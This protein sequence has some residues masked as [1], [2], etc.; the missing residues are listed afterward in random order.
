[1]NKYPGSLLDEPQRADG[2]RS[3]IVGRSMGVGRHP[4]FNRREPSLE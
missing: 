3:Q 2:R 4:I 1:M